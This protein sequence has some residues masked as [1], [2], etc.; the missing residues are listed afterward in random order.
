MPCWHARRVITRYH[1]ASEGD[2]ADQA[3]T[4]HFGPEGAA[5]AATSTE[6]DAADP[7][8]GGRRGRWLTGILAG[9]L[10]VSLAV[11]VGAIVSTRFPAS[12]E[13]VV[14]DF[15]AAVLDRDVD[16]ALAFVEP[17]HAPYG[18]A[19]AFLHPEAMDDSWR[20]M[21][22][23]GPL[24]RH[25]R[26]YRVTIGDERSHA[27]TRLRIRHSEQ[28]G[29]RVQRPLVEVEFPAATVTHWQVN[30]R[31]VDPS[32]LHASDPVAA[33]SAT[34]YLFPGRYAFF[35]GVADAAEAPA[36]PVLLLPEEE[37]HRAEPPPLAVPDQARAE[38]QEYVDQWLDDCVEYRVEHPPFC[39]FG[40]NQL[41]PDED[42]AAQLSSQEASL[43]ARR[44]FHTVSWRVAEYPTVEVLE[45]TNPAARPWGLAVTA[46]EPGVIELTV[47]WPSHRE[48]RERFT[49][50]C[51][52]EPLERYLRAALG[53]DRSLR[54]YRW[55]DPIVP[56]PA[57]RA[58]AGDEPYR[59][60]SPH[61]SATGSDCIYHPEEQ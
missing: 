5:T 24:G 39:P 35:G 30:D 53:P 4:G 49:A 31:V 15:F 18:A 17:D 29:W 54:L 59:G 55:P 60:G 50:F 14:A 8:R 46:A 47:T 38:A 41:V 32:A 13:S 22:I 28:L 23:A 33:A 16:A 3:V 26:T 51:P 12:P 25:G 37:P 56:P 52:V 57:S 34:Y 58:R 27:T 2:G 6:D 48:D 20:V 7:W 40:V 43:A 10:A 45:P 1:P 42:Y 44:S 19:A 9:L 36:E 61:P 11:L 21:E